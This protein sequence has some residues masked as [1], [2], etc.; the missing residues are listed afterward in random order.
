[1]IHVTKEKCV[2]CNACI[3]VCPVSSANHN[4]GTVVSV[5]PEECIQCGE[6]IRACTH[7]ARY[8]DDDLEMVM[9]LLKTQN[10]VSFLVAPAI[11]TAMDGR[12]RHVLK[13]LKDQ[14]AHEIY[15]GAFGADICTYMHV[16]YLQQNPGKKII[17]QPCAAIVN[18]A[19]KHKPKLL[20]KL[21][22]VQSPLMCT[23]VYVRKYLHN[24]DILVG[25]TPCIAKGTEFANTG[26]VKYNVT[27]KS[28]SEYLRRE[29]ITLP[30]GRSDFEF[31]AVRGFDGAF[32]PIPGGL[33][34]CL[35]AYDPDLLVATSEGVQKVYEDLGE[36]LETPE[37]SLPVVYDVLSCEFGCNSGAGAKDGFNNFSAYDIMQSARK[38]AVKRKGG[39][40]FHKKIFKTLRLEDFIRGYTNR[41]QTAE[42]TEK[43]IEE[44]F[45]QMGKFTEAE[46]NVD[47][48]A[49]GFK[50]CRA[51]AITIFQ[52]NNS[53]ANCVEHEKKHMKEMQT[54]I[55]EQA[56]SL[57]SSVEQIRAS[58]EILTLRLQPIA[59]Q[60]ADNTIKNASIKA[61][62]QTLDADM[63]NIHSRATAISG[64]V[65]E[66]S[67]SIDEYTKILKQ[68]KDISEQTNILA[69]NAT[70]E[71]ARAGEHGSGFAVVADE[72]RRL[73]V[74][75]A[76]TVLEAEE[77]T[78]AMLDHIKGITSATDMI[79][80]EVASTQTG[81]ERTNEAVN[82][83]E[84]SSQMISGS[85]NDVS[86][87]IRDLHGIAE[88]L[89][90]TD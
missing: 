29:K 20:E 6:C 14:G 16:Q 12:W 87:V 55:E 42:P 53:P 47:C 67:I 10:K 61:D 82:A 64:D 19:E 3:R 62:M 68:I 73:A 56:N 66:I 88:G 38:W 80:Q 76:D 15:D 2:G 31:S 45:Q 32:Y 79:M 13:W 57:R 83:L 9:R 23:A 49:C 69:I 33:K 43:Q 36:Y 81:V 39:D 5:N 30:T 7:G 85:V 52:G 41:C 22:P 44:I 58:L 86:E 65:S 70:I 51:M 40:R 59:E 77:H 89:V 26:I 63:L 78:N 25:L 8:Y 60:T 21:S 34:E 50:S 90:A 37:R 71:A 4:D 54:K 17:S 72:V 1:M 18:Y 74:K 48:H 24:N 84:A 35:H 11:K 27:F 28:L 46:R 75:S